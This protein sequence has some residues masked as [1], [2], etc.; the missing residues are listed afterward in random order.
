M[1]LYYQ[2]TPKEGIGIL[3]KFKFYTNAAYDRKSSHP[4]RYSFG[5]YIPELTTD[6]IYFYTSTFRLQ[7][8]TIL[9]SG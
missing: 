4:I 2:V 9:P 6:P 8:E 3:T 5:F 7:T 1:F